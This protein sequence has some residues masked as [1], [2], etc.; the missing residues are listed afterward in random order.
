MK[1][2]EYKTYVMSSFMNLQKTLDS[3]GSEGWELV[4]VTSE[5]PGG[6]YP[7]LFFKREVKE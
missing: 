5:I 2:W 1:K 4:A 6:A 3:I 7:L